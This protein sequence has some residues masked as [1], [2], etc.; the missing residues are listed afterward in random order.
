MRSARDR[1]PGDQRRGLRPGGGAHRV[2]PRG[3]RA[4]GRPHSGGHR[5]VPARRRRLRAVGLRRRSLPAVDGPGATARPRFGPGNLGRP[6]RA[7]ARLL[8]AGQHVGCDGVAGGRSGA[9]WVAR[10]CGERE[11]GGSGRVVGAVPHLAA[12]VGSTRSPPASTARRQRSPTR[13]G[14]RCSS[15]RPTTTA[16]TST[17]YGRRWA[18]RPSPPPGLPDKP[19]ASSRPSSKRR[20]SWA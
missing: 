15:R 6:Q 20:M 18:R 5:L 16:A 3:L 10:G 11:P 4:D 14:R 2:S 7:G 19:S 9:R 17:R 13:L 8:R 12:A 1:P